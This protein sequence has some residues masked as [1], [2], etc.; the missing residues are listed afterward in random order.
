MDSSF[1]FYSFIKVKRSDINGFCLYF[2]MNKPR[3]CPRN[4][5]GMKSVYRH[6]YLMNSTL[7]IIGM[8][9]DAGPLGMMVTGVPV[10]PAY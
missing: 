8:L 5:S 10:E 1:H 7:N 9:G 6:T 2:G 4:F 3:C